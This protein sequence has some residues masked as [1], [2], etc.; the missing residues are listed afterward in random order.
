MLPTGSAQNIAANVPLP[1]SDEENI[2]EP[3]IEL[4]NRIPPCK[5]SHELWVSLRKR[6]VAIAEDRDGHK[7]SLLD[8]KQVACSEDSRHLVMQPELF[9]T[10]RE[11][12]HDANIRVLQRQEAPRSR[13]LPEAMKIMSAMQDMRRYPALFAELGQKICERLER[14]GFN[15]DEFDKPVPLRAVDHKIY[16]SKEE[17]LRKILKRYLKDAGFKSRDVNMPK[18]DE[19]CAVK[20]HM[21]F[22]TGQMPEFDAFR[23]LTEAM[24]DLAAEHGL[25]M[26]FTKTPIFLNFVVQDIADEIL[27]ACGFYDSPATGNIT[28]GMMI[29]ACQVLFGYMMGVLNEENFAELVDERLFALVLDQDPNVM[30]DLP[31]TLITDGVDDESIAMVTH[32][33]MLNGRTPSSFQNI[34][35]FGLVSQALKAGL[36]D[37]KACV[38]ALELLQIRASGDRLQDRQIL[39]SKFRAIRVLEHCIAGITVGEGTKAAEALARETDNPNLK[40]LNDLF[41]E[42][43]ETNWGS[44]GNSDEVKA[45][46]KGMVEYYLDR[47][48]EYTVYQQVKHQGEFRLRPITQMADFISGTG[49]VVYP[50]DAEP[51]GVCQLKK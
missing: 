19:F 45:M 28:H 15:L 8:L 27:K 33:P 6:S 40:T 35:M 42:Y 29:H 25:A 36:N 24:T 1:D 30:A 49:Y 13:A 7:L 2:I 37:D 51:P 26:D 23:V 39:L 17:A 43:P 4:P 16:D 10:M 5:I 14:E 11:Y 31:V 38:Q 18:L 3:G 21:P 48:H 20:N 47:R 12:Y 34:L 46:L 32:R 9:S 50:A 41:R 22:V 44:F